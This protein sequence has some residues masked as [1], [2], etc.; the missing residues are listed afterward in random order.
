MIVKTDE[1]DIDLC[2]GDIV[3]AEFKPDLGDPIHEGFAI[4]E[5]VCVEEYDW[6]FG[7]VIDSELPEF[8]PENEH[9][10]EVKD[11]FGFAALALKN[12]KS[13]EILEPNLVERL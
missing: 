12:I 11:Y 4:V 5:L 10:W 6:V 9:T 1:G 7:Y 13:I 8:G 2:P 3:L